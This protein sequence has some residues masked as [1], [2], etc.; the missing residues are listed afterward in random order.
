MKKSIWRQKEPIQYTFNPNSCRDIL[1][2]TA[3]V[4][5]AL[6]VVKLGVLF[7]WIIY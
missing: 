7:G 3:G 2:F 1:I 6:V 5:S 4:V